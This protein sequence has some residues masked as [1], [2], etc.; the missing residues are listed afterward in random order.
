M[1]DLIEPGDLMRNGLGYLQVA[2]A[3]ASYAEPIKLVARG[4]GWIKHDG[5]FDHPVPGAICEVSDDDGCIRSTARK[6][7]EG[8]PIHFYRVT[9]PA[10]SQPPAPQP[11]WVAT[12]TIEATEHLFGKWP[13]VCF[14]GDHYVD[15]PRAVFDALD[16]S[17]PPPP[18]WEPEIG[19]E[20]TFQGN[21]V[22]VLFIGREMAMVEDRYR[23]EYEATISDLSPPKGDE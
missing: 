17:P 23:N 22:T 20:A 10:P 13:R 8:A 4:P 3:G 1:N 18:P 19:K 12:V 5:S 9:T 15:L 2:Q 16:W 14:P 7:G 6:A 21:D 11:G